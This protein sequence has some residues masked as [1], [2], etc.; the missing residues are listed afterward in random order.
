LLYLEKNA[1]WNIIFVL[2]KSCPFMINNKN[3]DKRI[4]N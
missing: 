3:L 2:G 4:N 1:L